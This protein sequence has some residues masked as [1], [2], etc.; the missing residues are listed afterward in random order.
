[1]T[2]TL[3]RWWWA[4]GWPVRE[5]LVLMVR[6]YRLTLG[7]VVG[8]G[9]RFHPSCSAYAER[10]LREVGV[11]RG[12]PLSIWRMLRCSPLT[13]GGVDY[14]PSRSARLYDIGIHQK[15]GS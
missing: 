10:A 2:D 3:R 1:M 4:A 5:A 7:K 15:A 6:G 8:G 9:C 13:K 14:P 11:L 12:V